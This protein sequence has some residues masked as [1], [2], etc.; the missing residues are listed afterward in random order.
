MQDLMKQIVEMDR[1]A[2]E[3]T[4]SAQLEKVNS[5]KEILKK[6]EQIRTEYLEKARKRIA[7]N[8]P[9]ERATA[10]AAWKIEKEKSV[11]LSKHLDDLYRE[12]GDHW[13]EEILERVLGA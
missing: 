10:E 11:K 1:N 9:K 2:R 6:R 3:I 12:N 4:D 5:E 8:E 7:L 13:V